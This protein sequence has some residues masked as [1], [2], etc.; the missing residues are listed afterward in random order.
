MRFT[1]DLK[2]PPTAYG[3]KL[4]VGI[5]LIVACDAAWLATTNR[6]VYS[7]LTEGKNLPLWRIV[8]ALLFYATAAA[9]VAGTFEPPTLSAAAASGALLGF[10]IF[11][12]YNVTTWS[13]TPG[14]P[15]L[16]ACLDVAY[17]VVVWA[18][19]LSVQRAV[20]QRRAR[21]R[22]GRRRGNV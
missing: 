17:G 7:V 18:A 11:T 20:V 21:R 14:W 13:T 15:I 9:A 8:T 12:V 16:N 5:P 22:G 19:L 6:A 2:R 3:L 10:A 4:A 1:V